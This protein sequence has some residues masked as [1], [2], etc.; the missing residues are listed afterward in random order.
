MN[1]I[2]DVNEMDVKLK[3]HPHLLEKLQEN[4]ETPLIS[5]V[6]RG[7]EHCIKFLIEHGAN[8]EVQTDGH[9]ALSHAVVACIKNDSEHYK[10]IITYLL[11]SGCDPNF[12]KVFEGATTSAPIL[13]FVVCS[14]L[15]ELVELFLQHGADPNIPVTTSEDE[16]C[17]NLNNFMI[18]KSTKSNKLKIMKLLLDYGAKINLFLYEDTFTDVFTAIMLCEVQCLKLLLLYNAPL[19]PEMYGCL[20]HAYYASYIQTLRTDLVTKLKMIRLLHKFGLNL[21][22]IQ[23]QLNE[24]TPDD[25]VFSTELRTL[26]D[27]PL[28]LKCMSRITILHTMGSNYCKNYKKLQ[29]PAS[30][31]D[32]LEFP[33][34]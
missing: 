1:T 26:C 33:D 23:R 3:Q 10:N 32:F 34:V 29:I 17:S 22:N 20:S 27:S 12:I 5:A 7:H 25:I 16:E 13:T 28:S 24:N 21:F 11:L 18:I 30:L 19:E 6:N 2:I 8:L 31:H 4:E 14:N 15:D 9:T